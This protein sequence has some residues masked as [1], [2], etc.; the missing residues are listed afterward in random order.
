MVD[1]RRSLG[2]V[3]SPHDPRDYKMH[4]ALKLPWYTRLWRWIQKLFEEGEPIPPPPG[5]DPLDF[6]WE[7]GVQLDQGATPHCVGF[8]SAHWLS[9]MPVEDPGVTDQI[10]HSLYYS[11]KIEDGEPGEENGTYVRSAAKVLKNLY[12]VDSY[13]FAERWDEIL[14]WLRIYGPVIMGTDWYDEMFDPDSDGVVHVGGRIAGGHCWLVIGDLPS[15][16]M[17][18]CQNSWGPEWGDRGR[19]KLHYDDLAVLF[20]DYGEACGALEQPL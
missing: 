5:P 15:Q 18:I 6:I 14:S 9:A 20:L 11:C 16:K 12:R 19:F 8:G 17:V 4:K 2:R 1:R 13:Y 7:Q 3:P 10:G